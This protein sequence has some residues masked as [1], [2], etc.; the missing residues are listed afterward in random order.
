M[1]NSVFNRQKVHYPRQNRNYLCASSMHY[2]YGFS[3]AYTIHFC[4]I[5]TCEMT[6]YK[7][8]LLCTDIILGL[9]MA[10]LAITYV[11]I[12]VCTLII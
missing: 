1:R 5:Y 3:H 12:Y 2:P 9:F 11:R 6:N 8:N 7:E 4:E 10:Y